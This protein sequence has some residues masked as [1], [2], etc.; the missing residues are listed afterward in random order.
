MIR[1]LPRAADLVLV[2]AAAL[3]PS[4][5]AQQPGGA[6]AKTPR[7]HIIGASVSGGFE[8][9]PAFGAK[10][11]GDT[12]ALQQLLKS[13]AGEHAR[14]TAHN[15]VAMVA[16]FTDP[17]EHGR[18]QIDAAKKARPDLVLAI[19]FAFWFAYG[20][21]GGDEAAA[22]AERF[23]RGLAMLAELE[24]PVLV[25][26][27]PDMRGAARRM[28]SPKQIPAPEIL[29]QLNERLAAF[30]AARGNVRVVAL[31]QAVRT[32][33]EQGTELDLA[34]GRLVTPPL[35]LL[36]EDRLHATRLGMAY[37]G[38]QLQ[39][40]IGAAFPAGSPLRTQRWT[41]DEFVAAAGAEGE[42][43]ALRRAAA[44]AAD[45]GAANGK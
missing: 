15:P 40:A 1:R 31:S 6:K 41:L 28:L 25:G 39:E 34:G 5:V 3:L 11:E 26:D 23:E 36:Q 19:D 2:L 21:V 24:M 4:A 32:L 43:D 8:D 20:H 10:E 22:R 35:A 9:G 13:W 12:V 29:R 30:A 14:V 45:G 18:A 7:L 27:L 37:L 33:R 42:I 17:D 16:M 44:P 38:S